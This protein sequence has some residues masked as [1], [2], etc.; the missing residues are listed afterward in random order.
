MGL[1]YSYVI[2]YNPND[3]NVFNNV[4]KNILTIFR[5]IVRLFS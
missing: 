4:K 5:E 1:T 2:K 3:G